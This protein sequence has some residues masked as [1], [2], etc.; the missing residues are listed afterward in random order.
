M[1]NN[2]TIKTRLVTVLAILSLMMTVIGIAG[3][4]SLSNSNASLQTVYEDRLVALGQLQDMI[5]SM[6]RNQLAMANAALGDAA[7]LPDMVK[8]VE[9]DHAQANTIWKA[10][11]A[12]QMTVEEKALVER[13]S[14]AHSAYLEQGLE[15]ALAAARA[16]DMEK[17]KSIMH[18]RMSERFVPVRDVIN[19][20]V[21]LQKDIGKQVYET[22]QA[23]FSSFRLMVIGILAGGLSLAAGIGWWLVRSITIPLNRAI[24]I[25]ESVAAGD[26]TQQIEVY[27]QDE[28]GKLLA[29]LREM[30]ISLV[31]IVGNVR[32]ATDSIN[33][34]SSEI[35]S[36]N[37]DLS[38]RT[39][40]QAGSLEETAS[41]LEELTSTVRQNAD[42]ARQ[43]NQ[44]AG[45]ASQVARRGGAVVSQVVDKMSAINES[46][47]KIVEIISV[48]DGIAFQTNILALNAAVEAARA[49]E[50]GRGFAVVAS[51]VRNLAQRAGAAAKEIKQLI[52][53]SVAQV[54]E[55]SRLVD[56]AG[57]TMTEVVLSV[58]QV[59]DII[60]EISAASGEQSAGLQQINQ[61]VVQMDSATQQNAALVEQAAAAAGAL[62]EQAGSLSQAVS[63]FRLSA[64]GAA[65]P[66]R[67][68]AVVTRLAARAAMQ[69]APAT[70]ARRTAL[71]ANS[72]RDGW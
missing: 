17:M 41:S 22:S 9:Q 5:R 60:G 53:N 64:A 13:F 71:A 62:Q 31:G 70:A 25:A 56:Q 54:E 55:G 48:I 40:Q 47:Y 57:S 10:Y 52:D 21:N 4:T 29:A 19:Q 69:P 45:N 61:A 67:R 39:E 33:T 7:A 72:T 49:G 11:I 8:G 44:L 50:Q 43:A 51:E 6:N 65:E 35:A 28:T 20:L 46:A 68:S 34:A 58:Q 23:S 12:T 14:A 1:L 38:A 63:V 30:S 27:T 15:P 16:G 2:L 26:L 42:N 66:A 37:V 59:T 24:R 18:G 32:Q 3:I 36:G